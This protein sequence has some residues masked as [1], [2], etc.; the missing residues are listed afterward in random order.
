M[1]GS[2]DRSGRSSQIDLSAA[3]QRIGGNTA[4]ASVGKHRRVA[5]VVYNVSEHKIAAGGLQIDIT[6]HP[7][8]HIEISA[9]NIHRQRRPVGTDTVV[10][11]NIKPLSQNAR[12]IGT[13][14]DRTLGNNIGGAALIVDNP[15][16][17]NV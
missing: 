7:V 15:A 17:N 11:G 1:P 14:S 10:G 6:L 3:D 12:I 9:R 2:A 16:Q 4:D 5:A 13:G 8:G